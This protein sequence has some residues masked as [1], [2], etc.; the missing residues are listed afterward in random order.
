MQ[1]NS[2]LLIAV[3]GFAV[4]CAGTLFVALLVIL[5]VTGRSAWSFLSLLIRRGD[6]D[7]DENEPAY[8]PPPRADLRQIAN[9]IDFETAVT[10]NI[11]EQR[12]FGADLPSGNLGDRPSAADSPRLRR[13]Q[14]SGD[15]NLPRHRQQ[16]YD[17]DEVFGGMLDFDGDGTPDT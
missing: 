13:A 3:A 15:D 9:A 6:G 8:I 17:Q 2:A 11:V 4:V 16:G 5:R 10:K 7:V 14:Q 12:E 1:D